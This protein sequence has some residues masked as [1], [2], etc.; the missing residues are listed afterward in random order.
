MPR[1][2]IHSPSWTT[3]I[4][5]FWLVSATSKVEPMAHINAV[6]FSSIFW[7]QDW[8]IAIRRSVIDTGT[9][10]VRNGSSAAQPL[11][12]NRSLPTAEI[13]V[14]GKGR[15]RHVNSERWRVVRPGDRVRM[16]ASELAANRRRI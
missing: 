1:H 15:A 11:K 8:Q 2:E 16:V 12:S 6:M 3:S 9:Y 5:Q 10:W 4:V 13:V 7:S 14:A